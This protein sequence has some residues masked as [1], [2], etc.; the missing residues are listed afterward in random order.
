MMGI[1]EREL[2]SRLQNELEAELLARFE[3]EAALTGADAGT[4]SRFAQQL[5]EWA[6]EAERESQGSRPDRR[7]AW[8]SWVAGDVKSRPGLLYKWAKGKAQA[9]KGGH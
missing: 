5:E 9:P 4:S 6:R 8:R 7:A 2:G 1:S 3:S